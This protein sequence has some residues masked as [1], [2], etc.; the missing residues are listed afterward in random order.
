MP[1][2]RDLLLR[3]RSLGRHCAC[4]SLYDESLPRAT[5]KSRSRH[6]QIEIEFDQRCRDRVTKV[7][8][9]DGRVLQ[10]LLRVMRTWINR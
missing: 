5:E 8:I 2:A 9:Q 1:L 7:L 3:L 4:P 10:G 6:V